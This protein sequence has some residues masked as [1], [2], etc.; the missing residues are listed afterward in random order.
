MHEFC[1]SCW[2]SGNWNDGTI[3]K[4]LLL[5]QHH[6]PHKGLRQGFPSQPTNDILIEA[7]FSLKYT[8]HGS[9]IIFFPWFLTCA[10]TFLNWVEIRQVW[11]K[12]F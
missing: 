3:V 8:E 11:W 10:E 7:S 1:C 12:K 2:I 9:Q 4:P 5:L 6:M